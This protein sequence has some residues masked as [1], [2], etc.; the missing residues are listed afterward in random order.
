MT[1]HEI[2]LE[3][4]TLFVEVTHQVNQPAD[5]TCR[6][7]DVDYYGYKELEFKV[8]SGQEYT[9]DQRIFELTPLRLAELGHEH[10]EL[11]EE[12]LW[13]LTEVEEDTYEEPDDGRW[14]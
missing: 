11:I 5:P 14:D 10:R 3:D 2:E 6:D 13:D 1:V 9:E 8:H 4:I 7:S 12:K